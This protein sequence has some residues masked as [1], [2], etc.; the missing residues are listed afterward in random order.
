MKKS[1]EVVV[2]GPFKTPLK[3]PLSNG[4]QVFLKRCIAMTHAQPL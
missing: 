3:S 4:G 2:Y 1:Q